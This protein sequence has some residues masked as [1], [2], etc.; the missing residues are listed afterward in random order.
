MRAA[1]A[2]LIMLC[3]SAEGI[4]RSL[5]IRKRVEFLDGLIEMLTE[6]AIEIRFRA[7][8]LAELLK[9]QS[10]DFAKLV[11]ERIKQGEAIHE[12]WENACKQYPADRTELALL[13]E[14]G[15]AFGNSDTEGELKLLGLYTQRFSAIREKA[16]SECSR[17]AK[18]FVQV[19]MLC[20]A[21]GAI[22]VL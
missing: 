8:T 16:F 4:R 19:G 2:I 10:S 17:K 15:R 6:F 1:A 11:K 20:G 14:F 7:P 9:N 22:L 21:A 3:C 13:S 5:L 18:A 12:A